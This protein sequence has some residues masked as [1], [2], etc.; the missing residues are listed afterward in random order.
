MTGGEGFFVKIF[1]FIPF[2]MVKPDGKTGIRTDRIIEAA[3]IAVVTAVV[4]SWGSVKEINVKL[5]AI[6]KQVDRMEQRYDGARNP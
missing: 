6:Q 2:L 4:V 3:I 5:D 1:P